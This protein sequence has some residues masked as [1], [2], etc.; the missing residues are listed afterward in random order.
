MSYEYIISKEVDLKTLAGVKVDNQRG[1][2][3]WALNVQL[4]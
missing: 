3:N 4:L 2:I 1:K